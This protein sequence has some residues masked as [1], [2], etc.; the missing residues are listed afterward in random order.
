MPAA[1]FAFVPRWIWE[2]KPR[3]PGS[4]YAQNFLGEVREGTAVPVN[5]VAEEYWNF[6][7]IG[8]ILFSL[9]YGVIIHRA[10]NFYLPRQDNP[11]VVSGFVLF[12]TTFHFST[13]DLVSFQQQAILL[14]LTLGLALLFASKKRSTSQDPSTSS[15]PASANTPHALG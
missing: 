4:L 5:P 9:L 10:H 2:E 11:F 14:F 12:V 7:I 8:V 1:V 6:G 15:Y 13:D 3:G